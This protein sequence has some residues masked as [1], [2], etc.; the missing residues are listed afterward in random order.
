MLVFSGIPTDGALPLDEG[1][2]E[3]A[4]IDAAAYGFDRAVDHD[5]WRR[6]ARRSVWL[7]DGEPVGYSYAFP[8]GSIGPVAGI[9]PTA[10]A[11]ALAGE[12]ARAEG[13]VLVRV[14]GSSRALVE[15]ALRSGLRL[16]PTPGLLL[17]SETAP[18][19]AS[20]AIAGYMLF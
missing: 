1:S 17:L 13:S 20:V 7:R 2:G 6:H 14:P 3:L 12:L 19:P 4:P 16:S 15:T 5:Y 18:L 8:D 9:D 10:A 11:A